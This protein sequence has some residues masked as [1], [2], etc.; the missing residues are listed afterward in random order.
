VSL[1]GAHARFGAVN[2]LPGPLQ[3][4][5]GPYQHVA[6]QRQ[7]VVPPETPPGVYRLLIG[8]RD[9]QTGHGI[10]RWWAGIVPMPRHTIEVGRIEVLAPAPGSESA[11]QTRAPR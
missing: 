3:G 5:G 11:R 10:R 9:G 2:P 8:V 6:V 1:R 7:I 4:L